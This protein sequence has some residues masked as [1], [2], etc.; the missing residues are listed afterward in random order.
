MVGKTK[1]QLEDAIDVENKLKSEREIS[2][3]RYAKIVVEYIV[4]GMVAAA[5]SAVLYKLIAIALE[6]YAKK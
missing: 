1:E 5:S 3:K 6:D 2:D 4:F